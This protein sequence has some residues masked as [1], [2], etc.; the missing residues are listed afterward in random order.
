MLL[1]AQVRMSSERCRSFLK[2][3]RMFQV[4]I[5]SVHFL[6][7]MTGTV[8]LIRKLDVQV[9]WVN[10]GPWSTGDKLCRTHAFF[11]VFGLYLSGAS[12]VCISVDRYY[13]VCKPFHITNAVRRAIVMIIVAWIGSGLLSSPEVR[14]R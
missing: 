7:L 12:V 6:I 11:K 1:P 14:T 4:D 5:H 13:A 9:G 2:I 8:L 3:L 10:Q